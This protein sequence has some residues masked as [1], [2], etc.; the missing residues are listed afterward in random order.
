M[1]KLISLKVDGFK[2][3]KI[4]NLTFPE[5][6]N[7]LVIGRNES[8][9]STLFE[10]IFFALTS[11]LLVVSK[12][13]SDVE[14]IAFEKNAAEIE[15][16]FTKNGIPAKIRKIIRRSGRG[17]RVEIN[18]WKNYGSSEEE[19]F[20]GNKKEL[21]SAIEEFLEFD[22]DILRNSCFVEQKGLDR[23][24]GDKPKKDRK[25]IITKLL[26]LDKLSNMEIQYDKKI[27]SNKIPLEYYGNKAK[28][29]DLT[30]EEH[31]LQDLLKNLSIQKENYEKLNDSIVNFKKQQQEFHGLKDS[32][33]NNDELIKTAEKEQETKS[34]ELKEI[35]KYSKIFNQISK[36]EETT[37]LE[38]EKLKLQKSNHLTLTDKS[39]LNIKKIEE[40]SIKSQE[41]KEVEVKIEKSIENQ[42]LHEI[43]KDTIKNI[44]ASQLEI[45]KLHTEK[46]NKE[47]NFETLKLSSI[48][49]AKEISSNFSAQ[50]ENFGKNLEAITQIS[51]IIIELREKRHE[52]Q[53]ILDNWNGSQKIRDK[54]KE[55]S[56]KLELNGV[57]CE[58]FEKQEEEFNNLKSKIGDLNKKIAIAQENIVKLRI[59]EKNSEEFIKELEEKLK[60]RKKLDNISGDIFQ[61][62]DSIK[63]KLSNLAEIK[64]KCMNYT[65]MI[66]NLSDTNSLGNIEAQER[67]KNLEEKLK[68]HHKVQLEKEIA[69]LEGI[70]KKLINC[71]PKIPSLSKEQFKR[72][73]PII[74]I[75]V[76]LGI[77]LSFVNPIL[78]LFSIF[79]ILILCLNYIKMKGLGSF[80]INNPQLKDLES[81]LIYYFNNHPNLQEKPPSKDIQDFS[82]NYIESQRSKLKII[83]NDT[84]SSDITNTNYFYKNQKDY[85]FEIFEKIQELKDELKFQQN[86]AVKLK[87]SVIASNQ[88]CEEYQSILESQNQEKDENERNIEILN[89]NLTLKE[90]EFE[91][92]K[93]NSPK[94]SSITLEKTIQERK[95][96]LKFKLTIEINNLS[97]AIKENQEDLDKKTEEISKIKIDEIKN[98]IQKT[99]TQIVDLTEELKILK[100]Q[101]TQYKIPE[102]FDI[103]KNSASLNKMNQQIIEKIAQ[104]KSKVLENN[105]I[106]KILDIDQ[107]IYE[108]GKESELIQHMENLKTSKI[109]EIKNAIPNPN[110]D[111]DIEN[112]DEILIYYGQYKD[113]NKHLIKLK[114]ILKNIKSEKEDL[115]KCKIDIVKKEE[116]QSTKKIQ[117]PEQFREDFILFEKE[118]LKLQKQ[119][120]NLTSNFDALEKYFIENDLKGLLQKKED[121][122]IDIDKISSGITEINNIINT[123]RK[124]IGELKSQIPE[125]FLQIDYIAESEKIQ[126]AKEIIDKALTEFRTQNKTAFSNFISNLQT[127]L[128]SIR[129]NEENTPQLPYDNLKNRDWSDFL[130]AFENLNHLNQSKMVVMTKNLAK[131]DIQD[132]ND[133][134][135]QINEK[136]KNI[137]NQ[138]G[139]IQENI[140]IFKNSIALIENKKENQKIL[141]KYQGKFPDKTDKELFLFFENKSDVLTTAKDIVNEGL[142]QISQKVLPKTEENL[143]KI[144]PILTADR[145]KDARV[146]EDYK[147]EL[148]DSKR[149]DYIE[150]TLFSGGTNDQIA[151]S[152]R[153]AFAMATTGNQN[154]EESFIFLD[155]PLGFFDDQRKNA[156]IDF[157]TRGSISKMFAQR[158]VVSNYLAI[159]P[160]FDFIIELEDGRIKEQKSTG[161]YDSIQF[162]NL[163]GEYVSNE[164]NPDMLELITVE[165]EEEDG[166]YFAEL[167][168]QNTSNS[169]IISIN[170]NKPEEKNID[171]NP[172]F[173][174]KLNPGEKREIT[175]E[176]HEDSVDNGIIP[177]IADFKF[178]ENE[179]NKYLKQNLEYIHKR[180]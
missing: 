94:D 91:I 121:I 178:L 118:H 144:L 43:W 90:S 55:I 164:G 6:G 46:K 129:I 146:T 49:Q 32:V 31:I 41:K 116:S 98:S 86:V 167:S 105:N 24:I 87:K 154:P 8:G 158:F 177:L 14:A 67:I 125:R 22:D 77:G 23:F 162:E 166:F 179:V 139:R 128:N 99:K 44:K 109:E 74:G 102:N 148:F 34:Q 111:M 157:L 15:L 88:K 143:T 170:I 120:G 83:Q 137:G 130:L 2:N 62:K 20:Q 150:K 97:I 108:T 84:K 165:R 133:I 56:Q 75:L 42:K 82:I 11:K 16:I 45:E 50:I 78:I 134:E 117:L 61:I 160:F 175:I 114:H 101:I 51:E 119:S 76:I 92:I 28:I 93:Q 12:K 25:L 53:D 172:V 57:N 9:K 132:D 36:I 10:A 103:K 54:S 40:N 71:Q 112:W 33:S 151:L 107:Q 95:N 104:L 4:N 127:F 63:K 100:T 152:L 110:F 1:L 27:K 176:F 173:I 138:T 59:E 17:A 5:N 141:K 136:E 79:G 169:E 29:Q 37:K 58:K 35:Q 171:V 81:D 48:E 38:E 66:E 3:L 52:S 123:Y 122:K 65:E 47:K 115:E 161:T 72:F 85:S 39:K 96:N 180:G 131:F 64:E 140:S 26:N 60:I 30:N 18:F 70:N 73:L 13:K 149:G 156:L 113:L 69:I 147:I 68:T 145:Y 163:R 89:K 80:Q 126:K 159:H 168:L 142:N 153:L 21:E 155:E 174:S 135:I 19:Y 7:I 124:T 106:L